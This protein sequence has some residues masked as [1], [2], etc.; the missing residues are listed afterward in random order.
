[1]LWQQS[2]YFAGE[3]ALKPLLH[4]W[5]LSLE[6][7]YYFLLPLL[8]LIAPK[9][10]WK[11]VVITLL[12]S[13]FVLCAIAV[14]IKPVATFYLLPTRAWEL[15]IGSLLAIYQF[16]LSASYAKI[17]FWPAVMA[18]LITPIYS[19]G[20]IHPGGD[21]LIICLATAVI[22]SVQHPKAD[23]QLL[24]RGLAFFG[25][26]SYSLYLVHWPIFAFL[27]NAYLVAPSLNIKIA[28]LMFSFFLGYFLYHFIEKSMRQQL[29]FSSRNMVFLIVLSC[30]ICLIPSLSMTSAD[31]AFD[32]SQLRKANPGLDKSCNFEGEFTAIDNCQSS[33][34]PTTLIWGDSFAMHL[35]PGIQISGERNII[36]AT[37]AMCGPILDIAPFDRGNH[38]KVWAKKCIKFNQSVMDYMSQN[39]SIKN[40]VMSSQFFV[41]VKTLNWNREYNLIKLE[42]NSYEVINSSVENSIKAL[43]NTIEQLQKMGKFVTVVAP[44]PSSGFNIGSCVEKKFTK[45]VTIGGSP[46]CDVSMQ[47]YEAYQYEILDLLSQIE[48]DTNVIYLSDGLCDETRCITEKDGVPYYVDD[49]HLSIAGSKFLGT[50][51]QWAKKISQQDIVSQTK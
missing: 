20:L 21:A 31:A 45:K 15:M 9:K 40:V 43:R 19:T 17:L 14:Q 7:Q 22:I 5:S 33:D 34:S 4:I 35:I 29:R 49:G 41:Y 27:N 8:F 2:D 1:M 39:K 6:E 36:Q 23:S 3:S 38:S 18:L 32:Y 48:R 24:T 42:N 16:R 10:Y 30:V 11:P 51:M 46:N 50:K 25:G 12:V 47:N 28:A 13:S 26:F 44:P 37:S